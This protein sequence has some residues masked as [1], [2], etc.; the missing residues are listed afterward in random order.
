M[1]VEKSWLYKI[2]VCTMISVLIFIAVF[3]SHTKESVSCAPDDEV[4]LAP[5]IVSH[6]LDFFTYIYIQY[7]TG[8]HYTLVP[9][10][11]YVRVLL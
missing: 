4:E 3:L 8:E 6:S 9:M 7:I 1:Y 2:Y 5:E 11:W 10:Y